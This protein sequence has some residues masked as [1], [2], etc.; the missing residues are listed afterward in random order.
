MLDKHDHI[1][2]LELKQSFQFE[3][4]KEDVIHQKLYVTWT[5]SNTPSPLISA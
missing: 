4:E 2:H 3:M 1:S 5:W